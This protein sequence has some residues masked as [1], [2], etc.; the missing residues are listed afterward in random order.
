MG[1]GI[2]A[3]CRPRKGFSLVQVSINGV[4]HVSHHNGAVPIL[5]AFN[6]RVPTMD[7]RVSPSKVLPLIVALLLLS[8]YMGSGGTTGKVAGRVT[9]T[10]TREPLVAVNILVAGTKLGAATDADGY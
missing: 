1:G 9:D 10:A 5:F 8:P 7:Q 2:C 6:V 3:L 4:A